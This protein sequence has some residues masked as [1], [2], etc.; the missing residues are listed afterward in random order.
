MHWF[1][2]AQQASNSGGPGCAAVTVGR[3]GDSASA[4][5]VLDELVEGLRL[6][7]GVLQHPQQ[8]LEQDHLAADHGAAGLSAA[9]G[10]VDEGLEQR[11]AHEVLGDEVPAARPADVDR[12][13]ALGHLVCAVERRAAHVAAGAVGGRR[14]AGDVAGRVPPPHHAPELPQPALRHSQGERERERVEEFGEDC[15]GSG[16]DGVD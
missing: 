9:A 1:T 7:V 11:V 15:K 13:Q 10:A 16:D 5:V 6:R 8:V 4:G 3:A 12:V 2:A 14:G